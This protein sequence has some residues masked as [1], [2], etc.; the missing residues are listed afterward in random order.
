MISSKTFPTDLTLLLLQSLNS[1]NRRASMAITSSSSRHLH[2]AILR[3][4]PL[5]ECLELTL[6]HLMTLRALSPVEVEEGSECPEE[7]EEDSVPAE[8][9]TVRR[10]FLGLRPTDF[11]DLP[12]E[13]AGAFT[14]TGSVRGPKMLT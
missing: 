10:G 3:Q 13:E 12:E 8:G 9:L 5:L 7:T 2:P 6:D 1:I 11:L 4:A 14:W